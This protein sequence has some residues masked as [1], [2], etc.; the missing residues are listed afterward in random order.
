MA[1]SA[2]A[3]ARIALAR[4]PDSGPWQGAAGM[5]VASA[6]GA[7]GLGTSPESTIRSLRSASG[8]GTGTAQ[9]SAS[10]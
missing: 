2:R 5:E 6:G 1:T 8:S 9:S 10:V 3:A 7:I 4:R